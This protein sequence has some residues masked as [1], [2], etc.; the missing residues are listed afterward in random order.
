M[1]TNSNVKT[2]FDHDK[3]IKNSKTDEFVVLESEAQK[4]AE[5]AWKKVKSSLNNTLP[6]IPTDTGNN[7]SESLE[8]LK[9]IKARN[10]IDSE[11]STVETEFMGKLRDWLKLGIK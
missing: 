3:V 1:G 7:N 4:K 11:A 10:L 5:A 2:A 8:L 6:G 9:A